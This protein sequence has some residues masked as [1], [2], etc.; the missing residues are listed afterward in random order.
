MYRSLVFITVLL[1]LSGVSLV[2]ATEEITIGALIPRTGDAA[3]V[4]PGI[5]AAIGLAIS[6]LNESYRKAGLDVTASVQKADIDGAKETAA[7]A[8]EDLIARGAAIIV[9]PP[10]SGEVEGM[11]PILIEKSVISVNPSTSVSLSIPGD[12][13][14]RLCP[15]DAQMLDAVVMY[16]SSLDGYELKKFVIIARDDPYGR[17]L[18]DGLQKRLPVSGVVYYNP[19]TDDFTKPLNELDT[20]VTPLV[21]EAGEGNVIVFALSYNEITS[22]LAEAAGY[23]SLL[24]ASWQASDGVALNP[25][26]VGN[27]IVARFASAT[28]LVALQYNSAQPSDSKYW[29]V[30]DTIQAATGNDKPTIYEILAYDQTL[31]AAWI[32]QNDPKNLDEM[33]YLA[34][35]YGEYSYGATGWLKL[36]GNGDRE[37]GDYYFYQVKEGDDGSFFWVPVTVYMDETNMVVPLASVTN[38]FMDH[39]G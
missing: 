19:D 14:I 4:G 7:S 10:T 13:V 29:R 18:S 15:D 8:T 27:E 20:L 24:Q 2:S 31:F 23:P 25:D 6:D 26:I 16:E 37:Y 39:Y 30:Y 3:S 33:L 32:I 9:G 1:L 35:N 22:I 36:N 12:P 21:K 38:P 34:D 28:G 5:E 11:L 17:T